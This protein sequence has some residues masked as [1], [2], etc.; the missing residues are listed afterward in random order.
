MIN[1]QQAYLKISLTSFLYLCSFTAA[2][3][4]V[5]ANFTHTAAGS[6]PSTIQFT[7]TSTGT[8]VSNRWEFGD[9]ATSTAVH[10]SHQYLYAGIY[11]V[12]L[13][14]RNGQD[15]STITKMISISQ[16]PSAVATYS[17]TMGTEFWV[18]YGL[19]SF[20]ENNTNTQHMK[21]YITAGSQPAQVTVSIDSSAA[22]PAQWFRRTYSVPANT[23]IV[24]ESL[25]KGTVNAS[26]SGSDPLYDARL[27]TEPPPA[28]PGSEGTFRKKGIKVQSNVPVAVQAQIY[29]GVTSGMT[30]LL[31]VETWGLNY[32]SINSDQNNGGGTSS[33]LYVIAKEDSTTVSITPSVTS[34]LGKPANTPFQVVLMKGWIYQLPGPSDASGS[35]P[36]LTGTAIRSIAGADGKY[37]PIAVFAGSGRT[38]G[39]TVPCT[40]GGRDNDIQQ[41]VPTRSWGTLFLTAPVPKAISSGTSV[42]LNPTQA[43][44]S[45]YK[46]VVTD[47]AT[48]VRRNG[49]TLT[50]L[51]S[52]S[53]YKFS[54]NTADV[55]TSDKP[56]LIAQFMSGSSTCNGGLGDPDMVFIPP[57]SNGTKQAIFART[58]AEAITAHFVTI[59]VPTVALG[60]LRID[61]G[62]TVDHVY[63]H[64]NSPGYSVV[65]KGWAATTTSCRIECDSA[66]VAN[67]YG[68]GSAE[69][70]AF[71][72]GQTIKT[73]QETLRTACLN[74]GIVDFP[75]GLQ[76]SNY[77][78]QVAS[79]TGSFQNVTD[80][81]NYS[82]SNTGTLQLSNIVPEFYGNRYRCIVDGEE[83]AVFILKF[84]N[85]WTG[86]SGNA[87]EN[88]ANWSCGAVPA[89]SV[90][91][92]IPSGA[93]V[94]ISSN[95]TVRS[96]KIESGATVTV[97]PGY[98]LSVLK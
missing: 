91:I 69:S 24:T 11:L 36:N 83:S 37:H 60:S 70:F 73:G 30:T 16:A 89:G 96:L 41:L 81:A 61:G 38:G 28:G 31:P 43:Q 74:A 98:Q 45:V 44:T 77:K 62:S 32:H 20:M 66:F 55:I 87:W 3:T 59:I 65:V 25:P 80:N 52:D 29:G 58:T 54:S 1:F 33:W 64:P 82:G 95:G 42:T 94:V 10:P 4:Q 34:K 86:S 72:A 78:W 9:G 14:V 90:D 6:A 23:S 17:S 19:H 2:K 8:I 79:S 47:P 39:E 88:A 40:G 46:I 63:S 27:F 71:N 56:V 85:N 22:N 18:G 5:S 97:T 48:V 75:A 49:S 93:N 92:V 21:L 67:C 7:N 50:G 84:S 53:Y 57:T 12:S 76:G 26:Q 68:L 13:T 51:I 15:S 35:A